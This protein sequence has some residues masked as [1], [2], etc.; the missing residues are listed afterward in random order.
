MDAEELRRLIGRKEG[1]KLDFKRKFYEID[2]PEKKVS[3]L[4]SGELIKDVLSLANA[5][6]WATDQPGYL[7]V[8]V[9][10]QLKGDRRDLFDVGSL[11]DLKISPKRLLEKVNGF[12]RPPLADIDCEIVPLDGHRILVISIPF[13]PHL[14]ETTKDI[15][16]QS[17][18]YRE[19]TVFIR[20]AESVGIASAQERQAIRE[21]KGKLT[22]AV[23]SSTQERA[24][25]ESYLKAIARDESELEKHYI[26]LSGETQATKAPLAD[27]PRGLIPFSFRVLDSLTEA[28][29]GE[30][31]RLDAIEDAFKIHSRFVLLGSPGSGKT[32]TLLKLQLDSAKRALRDPKERIPVFINLAQWPE[33]I[34]DVPDLIAHE[35]HLKG[36]P[37]VHFNSLLILFDGLNEMPAAI[38]TER[39][40]R[41]EEWLHANPAL[42]FIISCRERDYNEREKLSAM[43]AVQVSPLD[44][45]RI[46][47]LL[48]A[49]LGPEKAEALFGRM[50]PEDERLRSKRDLIHLASNPYL[51]TMIIYVYMKQG[52]LPSSRGQLFQMFVKTLYSREEGLH[53]VEGIGYEEMVLGLSKLALAM[54]VRRMAT[55]VRRDWAASQ[56]P[57]ELNAERLWRLGSQASLLNPL[58]DGSIQFSHQLLLE[59]FAAEGLLSDPKALKKAI[60]PPTFRYG[61]RA[62]SQWDEVIYTLVGIT[63]PN[64]M[65][66]PLS[67]S[68]PFLAAE[69]LAHTP[70]HIEAT[71]ETKEGI[72]KDLTRFFESND[73]QARSAAVAKLTEMGE[74]VITPLLTV[75]ESGINKARR[76]S[77]VVLFQLE[78]MRASAALIRAL[79]DRDR[80]VRKDAL[81]FLENTPA[82]LCVEVGRSLIKNL[83][84]NKWVARKEVIN[85]LASLAT[86]ENLQLLKEIIGMLVSGEA[87]A[88][89]AKAIATAS[90]HWVFESIF[91]EVL[92]SLQVL[93]DSNFESGVRALSTLTEALKDELKVTT[94]YDGSRDVDTNQWV[95]DLLVLANSFDLEE[96]RAFAIEEV[97]KLANVVA[98]DSLGPD[99]RMGGV[100]PFDEY[101][102]AINKAARAAEA[103]SARSQTDAER[104]RAHELR[105]M[106]KLIGAL[107][108]ANPA[109]GRKAVEEFAALGEMAVEPLIAMLGNSNGI[110]R[111]RAP[112]ALAKI[113]DPRALAPLAAL[114]QDPDKRVRL[115]AV[116][117]LAEFRDSSVVD[118][119]IPSLQDVTFEVRFHAVRALKSCGDAS[120]IEALVPLL[121]DRRTDIVLEAAATLLNWGYSPA[122]E[123]VIRV[124]NDEQTPNSFRTQAATLLAGSGDSRAFDILIKM[125]EAG[126]ADLRKAALKALGHLHDPRAVTPLLEAL[127]DDDASIRR[128]ASAF[129]RVL[130]A[131]EALEPLMVA[132][133]DEDAIVRANAVEAIGSIGG[134]LA[135]NSLLAAA[136]DENEPV[137]I[138]AVRALGRLGGP[139]VFEVL[140]EAIWDESVPVRLCAVN[141]LAAE[142]INKFHPMSKESANGD[143]G[144]E[145]GY[146]GRVLSDAMISR[147][148]ELLTAAVDDEDIGVRLSAVM[149]FGKVG[150]ELAVNPLI[151]SLG[152][153]EAAVRRCAVTCLGATFSPNAVGPLINALE[154]ED[155]EVRIGAINALGELRAVRAIG[156][157]VRT[158]SDDDINVRANAASV[159][160]MLDSQ[161]AIE[162]WS[163]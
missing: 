47:M 118:W 159:L 45:G 43:P 39:I 107:R 161:N 81:T 145:S 82:P 137:R 10:D 104:L 84:E 67:Q 128:S 163:S 130:Q 50:C 16:A 5:N 151:R 157:L 132:A 112:R 114:L 125:L 44:E 100:S 103:K 23:Q 56:I 158:L 98:F 77:L 75:L 99:M 54:H 73:S 146:T 122:L 57:G 20:R 7:V 123:T 63:D 52:E 64:R 15:R 78:T 3:E 87:G 55:T 32:V 66:P 80:W 162:P 85:V 41:I 21:Y 72:A 40:K 53:A 101:I 141:G 89:L 42:S 30:P 149:A 88:K 97:R 152:D 86:L 121:C 93:S 135:L 37:P 133:K 68:D 136:S 105:A 129:L 24:T 70:S 8:G 1:L 61:R 119:L 51:L 147:A 134:N 94:S 11:E 140:T 90:D 2:H 26:P 17:G 126:H 139:E 14:H 91:K 92:R 106:R 148:L 96:A 156:P 9:G 155:I 108:S 31:K 127:K 4:Q 113:K 29:A 79:G 150:G 76:E 34:T 35:C 28:G 46:R 110:L 12:C 49:Y 36:L 48:R 38:Y 154:D 33:S 69:C 18:T 116:K 143:T 142:I 13:S 71:A 138:N 58:S 111:R 22:G 83:V 59:Y 117:S 6:V 95:T 109:V 74:V 131:P 120:R 102:R 115:H 27:M 153:D 25:I 62:V 65:L 124:V 19:H 60:K 144:T 160:H